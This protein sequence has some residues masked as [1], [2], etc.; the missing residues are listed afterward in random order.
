VVIYS[1][2]HSHSEDDWQQIAQLGM[3]LAE[4]W[5]IMRGA[6]GLWPWGK[7]AEWRGGSLCV[8]D[9]KRICVDSSAGQFMSP[10]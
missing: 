1:D 8:W 7:P 4:S 3:T 6:V 5:P 10:S 2:F 9:R